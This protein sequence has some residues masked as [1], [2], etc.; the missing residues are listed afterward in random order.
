[1]KP[2]LELKPPKPRVISRRN[3][4]G[5]IPKYPAKTL[6]IA[7]GEATQKLNTANKLLNTA[8]PSSHSVRKTSKFEVSNLQITFKLPIKWMHRARC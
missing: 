5:Y 7:N 4:S 2:A 3:L 1:M 8:V 6:S